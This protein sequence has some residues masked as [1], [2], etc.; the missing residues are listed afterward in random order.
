MV[1]VLLIPVNDSWH[2]QGKR[3]LAPIQGASYGA[4]FPLE[5]DSSCSICGLYPSCPFSNARLQ[6]L[7]LKIS[8]CYK[9]IDSPISNCKMSRM[10]GLKGI[11]TTA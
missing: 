5:I 11:F 8:T 2:P 6:N 9:N 4:A 1:A 10:L 3:W 7:G